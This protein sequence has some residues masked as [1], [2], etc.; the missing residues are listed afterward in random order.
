MRRDQANAVVAAEPSPA[1][2]SPREERRLASGTLLEPIPP[3]VIAPRV[4]ADLP[5]KAP[6]PAGWPEAKCDKNATG[7]GWDGRKVVG[8]QRLELWT[9][10]LKVRCSTN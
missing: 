1:L 7:L 9:R 8:R 10:G 3:P 5:R 6:P 4:I 2:S